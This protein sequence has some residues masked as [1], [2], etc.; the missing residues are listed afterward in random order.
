MLMYHCPYLRTEVWVGKVTGSDESSAKMRIDGRS[1][2]DHSESF[3]SGQL[4]PVG[5]E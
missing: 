4:V 1:D 5:Y 2:A 3:H